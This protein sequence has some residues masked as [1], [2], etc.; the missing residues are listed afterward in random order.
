MGKGRQTQMK[1]KAFQ[2]KAKQATF[3]RPANTGSGA[4]SY[5]H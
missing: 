5:E 3:T 2:D 4:S 1:K